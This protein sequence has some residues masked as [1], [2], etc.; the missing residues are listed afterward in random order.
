MVKLPNVPKYGFSILFSMLVLN[1]FLRKNC[2]CIRAFTFTRQQA[3]N[4]KKII[5]LWRTGRQ[6]YM[7]LQ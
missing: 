5:S 4:G 2:A 3:G 6:Y 7:S 1:P